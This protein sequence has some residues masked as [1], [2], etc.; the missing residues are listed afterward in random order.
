VHKAMNRFVKKLRGCLAMGRE[1]SSQQPR[2]GEARGGIASGSDLRPMDELW[3]GRGDAFEKVT[4]ALAQ[5]LQGP[6]SVR[7]ESEGRPE[8]HANLTDRNRRG[9]QA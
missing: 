7:V 3:K 2:E 6:Y 9:R 4:Q 1:R 5:V 8:Q